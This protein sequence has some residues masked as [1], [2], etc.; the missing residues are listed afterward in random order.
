[1]TTDRRHR[2]ARPRPTATGPRP[3][4][5]KPR[6]T[7]SKPRPAAAAAPQDAEPA[8]LA[9]MAGRFSQWASVLA[10]T[11]VITAMLLYFGYIGTRARFAYFGVYLDLTDLSNQD[12]VLYGLEILYVPVAALFL[13]VLVLAAAHLAVSRA[14]ARPGWRRAVLISAGFVALAGLLL[15]ARSLLGLA[16]AHV[17]R[18]EVPGTTALALAGG[19]ALL[20]YAGWLAARVSPGLHAWFADPAVRTLRRT[21]LVAIAGL[22]LTG[23]FWAGTSFAWRLGE[24][25]AYDDAVQLPARPQVVLD[26][27]ERLADLPPLV[28]ETALPGTDAE[29]E[30]RY[31]YTGL[32]LLIE[33]GGRLFLVPEQWTAQGRTLIVPY[34]E[35]IR[36]R[37]GP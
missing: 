2:P 8:D 10:P 4:A 23:L 14:A 27:R 26:T 5:S 33:A 30:F 1:M 24:G 28:R 35:H 9:T 12:L 20:G 29:S 25:R 3:A 34:D 31:R 32:R 15:V 36:L 11:T 19:P 6:P 18:A 7:A 13:A 21:G 16:I 17:A 37:V 22:V